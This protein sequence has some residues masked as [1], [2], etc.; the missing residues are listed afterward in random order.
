MNKTVKKVFLL[1]GLLVLIFLVWQIVFNDGG[2]VK[3]VYNAIVNGIN[4]QW[5]KVAG[6]GETLLPT[7]DDTDAVS[8][9]NGQGFEMETDG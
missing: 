5:E 2:I 7:W 3:T 6:D 1:I 8:D 4:G 9:A